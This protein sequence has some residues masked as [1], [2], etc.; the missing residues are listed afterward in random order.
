[1]ISEK[2]AN[3]LKSARLRQGLSLRDLAERTGIS[4]ET[5]RRAED[6]ELGTVRTL[7]PQLAALGL[8]LRAV[9]IRR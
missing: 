4:Y 8:E 3:A 2:I 5:I 9:R 1:M 7:G 6:G